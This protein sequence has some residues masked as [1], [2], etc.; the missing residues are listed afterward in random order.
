MTRAG[1]F[2][3]PLTKRSGDIPVPDVQSPICNVQQGTG[4]GD[5]NVPAP[6]ETRLFAD[7]AKFGIAAHPG[8]GID[9][10]AFNG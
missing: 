4:A 3:S 2:L 5:R 1:T 10:G 8:C 9:L 7:K 6:L